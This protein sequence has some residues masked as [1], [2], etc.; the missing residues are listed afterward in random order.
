MTGTP[1]LERPIRTEIPG[2]TSVVEYILALP[3]EAKQV[4]LLTLLREAMETNGDT[5]L[6][7]IDDEHGNSFGYYVPP[8]A[9][10]E[11]ATRYGPKL[12]VEQEIEFEQRI[13]THGTAV[14]LSEVIA[15]LKRQLVERQHQSL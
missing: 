8:K 15:D 5:G 6:L 3:F 4:A 11:R 2:E 9:A 14:P 7:A 1:A 13:E 10:A 12:T